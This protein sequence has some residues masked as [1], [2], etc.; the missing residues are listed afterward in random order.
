MAL[1]SPISIIGSIR[2]WNDS[3]VALAETDDGGASVVLFSRLKSSWVETEAVSAA[4]LLSLPLLEK[5]RADSILTN[6]DPI[7]H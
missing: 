3:A 2:D 4:K 5:A 7:I 1:K 6:P